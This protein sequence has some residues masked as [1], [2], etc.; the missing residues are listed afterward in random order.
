MNN[1]I[2]ILCDT[3]E[4]DNKQIK[5]WFKENK[6]MAFSTRLATGDYIAI[7]YNDKIGFY[8]EREIVID[9]KNKILEICQNLCGSTA[10][11]E[12]EKRKLERAKYFGFKRFVFLIYDKKITCI[13]DLNEWSSDRTKIKG[14][15]LAKVL[16][17]MQE[18]YNCEF[19][20]VNDKKMVG[21]EIFELLNNKQT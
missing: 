15:T 12:K 9:L 19:M 16:T 14:S 3:L 2:I 4:K 7:K 11:H 20:F 17:T 6:I 13:E 1:K 10:N 8:V 18:K 5:Q 21:K